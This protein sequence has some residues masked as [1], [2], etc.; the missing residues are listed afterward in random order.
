MPDHPLARGP[1]L[2]VVTLF[3]RP[4]WLYATPMAPHPPTHECARSALS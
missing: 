4:A 2:M 1:T 3:L